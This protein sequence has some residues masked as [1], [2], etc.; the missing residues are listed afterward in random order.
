MAQIIKHR[1]GSIDSLK[2]AL[3]NK[4]ELVIATGSIG[5]MNGP[6]IFVGDSDAN[7]AF[8]STA[9]IYAGTAV[10]TISGVTYGTTLDGVPFYATGNK[11][12]YILDSTGNQ[13]IDLTGN[14]EGNTIS[15]VSINALTASFVSASANISAIN[16]SA[17]FF[18]GAFVG[19]ASGLTNVP[20]SGL[21]GY[22]TSKI[23][24]GSVQV[25]TDSVTGDINVDAV[26]NVNISGSNINVTGSNSANIMGG[27][28]TQIGQENQDSYFY[29]EPNYAEMYTNGNVYI[30]G[31]DYVDVT[32][33]DYDSGLYLA[34]D[35]NFS[36]QLYS[37]V[38]GVSLNGYDG[39][40]V[41]INAAGGEGDVNVLNGSNKINI[42]GNSNFTGS[43][44]IS[45]D[46]SVTGALVV[47]NGSATFDQGL[48][49]QNSNMLLTSGSNL[50]IQDGGNLE[51]AG[52]VYITGSEYVDNIYTRTGQGANALHLNGGTFGAPDVEL[53]SAGNI[54]L[55]AEGGSPTINVTGSIK[56]TGD[57][58]VEQNM[59]V[60][61]N[62]YQTGSFYTQ[63]DIVLSGSINIGNFTGDTI[64]FNGEVTTNILPQTGATYNLGSSGQTW[65][66]VHAEY[67][68]G[69][70][71]YLTNISLTGITGLNKIVDGPVSASIL[72]VG[73]FQVN[74]DSAITGALDVSG[75]ITA[76]KVHAT[77]DGNG[78][79][80]Q[81][82][83]DMWIGDVNIANTM[84]VAGFEDFNKGYIQFGDYTNNT[85]TI[86]TN[87]NNLEL[88]S[89]HNV[90]V[91][92]ED[93]L[94]INGKNEVYIKG[95]NYGSYIDIYSGY[96]EMY[97]DADLYIDAENYMEIYV[98]SGN[99]L[100][101]SYDGGI[102]YL[103]T[104]GGEGDI[105]AGNGSNNFY[106][107][108]YN[109]FI[110][111]SNSTELGQS[112]YS[113]YFYTSNDYAEMSSGN[114]VYVN[115]YGY[116]NV[117]YNEGDSGLYLAN[118]GDFSAQ[119]YTYVGGVS[120]NSYNGNSVKINADGG[121]GD[122]NVLN[123]SNK[124]N[125]NGNSN[126]TGSINVS[127][128]VYLNNNNTLYATNIY[129]YNGSDLYIQTDNATLHINQ[130]YDTYIDSNNYT[131][132]GW[133]DEWNYTYYESGGIYTWSEDGYIEMGGNNNSGDYNYV[134]IEQ[135]GVWLQTTHYDGTGT[136]THDVWL[137]NTGSLNLVNVNLHTD[138]NIKVGGDLEVTG[139]L[140]VSGT[141]TMS[142]SV[143]MNS[144]LYVS[145]NIYVYGTG[146]TVN[147]DSNT[148][149]IGDNIILVNAYSPFQRYAG[150]A[151]YDSGSSGN[152]GSLLW[153]SLN[154]YWNFVDQYD[155]SSQIIGTTA[156]GLG[157]EVSL[158]ANT[159][160]KAT[161]AN[162]IGN[163]LITDDG[164]VFTY[165]T[166]KFTITGDTGDTYINGNLQIAASGGTDNGTLTS[167]IVFRNSDD[168]LGFVDT[169]D[170]ETESDA[171]LGYNTSTGVLQFSSLIDG[172]LY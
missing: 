39:N 149:N 108:S 73:G 167:Y 54:S 25:T 145:G 122:V 143:T 95:D 117:E 159:L 14:I 111:G 45:G 124:I 59:Y 19:D 76:D 61:G 153:D 26:N 72:E 158:T 168:M 101:S 118:D 32:Y 21:T 22:D 112:D 127:G 130:S 115:G 99:L 38:G 89:D 15:G 56:V 67:Y 79:N 9:K 12:L 2:G 33:N 126:F 20:V 37:Y 83:N 150:I 123:G 43:V 171:L 140:K 172:G 162:T 147:L 58:T 132:I 113:A 128:D 170:T 77:N 133:N 48:V 35:G 141:T 1:R 4:G 107:S 57:V 164:T 110:S 42:N 86:G 91:T 29:T 46:T 31:N 16:V 97:S 82:G 105:H 146:T 78:Q 30:N 27:S 119:L 151:G 63:G 80:F 17:S 7:G 94:E 10:P 154:N 41:F 161:S 109:T 166:N 68:Y 11:S 136:T 6:W 88:Y 44:N 40:G 125:I 69:D 36:A 50:I 156:A 28:W 144:D 74:T 13:K 53:T 104:D 131:S 90:Y 70:G 160:P 157:N 148:V 71:S 18:T 106:V 23:F 49:A 134:Y 120:L 139:S 34:S 5:N 116:V 92:A 75:T 169:T 129:G 98:N 85:N 55:F 155:S 135:D 8:K 65:N 165:N 152:S 96:A 93:Y 62:I 51:V 100:I 24:S 163:S 64:N 137:D 60:S 114:Q 52:N 102:L 66:E 142:G 138:G 87:G 47:S 3:A 81:V 103:N 121:E 84:Q